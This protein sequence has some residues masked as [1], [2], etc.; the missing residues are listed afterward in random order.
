V[1]EMSVLPVSVLVWINFPNRN[2][3]GLMPS[4]KTPSQRPRTGVM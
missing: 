3:A 1:T 4:S 2:A